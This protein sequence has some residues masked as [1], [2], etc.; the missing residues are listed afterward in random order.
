MHILD[1]LSHTTYT[2]SY[3]SFIIP[4]RKSVTKLNKESAHVSKIID[5]VNKGKNS[6]TVFNITAKQF[7]TTA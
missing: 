6:Q 3:K 4:F 5:K 7:V 2:D 1:C